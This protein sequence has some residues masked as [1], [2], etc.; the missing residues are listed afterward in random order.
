MC[1]GGQKKRAVP[2]QRRQAEEEDEDVEAEFNPENPYQVSH[3][4]KLTRPSLSNQ[5]RLLPEKAPAKEGVLT[6]SRAAAAAS[7][8]GV[9]AEGPGL[10]LQ[11]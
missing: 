3:A 11:I 7:D 8:A 4:D 2:R 9:M 10:S 6:A 1:A 5:I